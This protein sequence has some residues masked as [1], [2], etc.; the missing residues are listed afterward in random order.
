MSGS[1]QYKLNDLDK[2][3]TMNY[4][5][6]VI[7]IGGY[8]EIKD[9]KTLTGSQREKA[10]SNVTEEIKALLFCLAILGACILNTAILTLIPRS[11]SILYPEY[12]YEGLVAFI[13]GV[14][15]RASF[16]HILELFIFTKISS[17]VTT[18]HFHSL[19]CWDFLAT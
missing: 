3:N 13:I 12:W 18:I 9:N 19:V 2:N 6:E 15:I 17:L 16:N 14:G 4:S 1:G 10:S 7:S 8:G 11:N 5:I